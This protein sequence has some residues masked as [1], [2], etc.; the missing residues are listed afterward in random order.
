MDMHQIPRF[1]SAIL[2]LV[3]ATA[4]SVRSTVSPVTGTPVTSTSTAATT[5]TPPI[6]LE[7][8]RLGSAEAQCATLKVHENRVTRSGRVIELRVALIKAQSES[9]APDPIFYLAGGPG[10]AAT[11]DGAR[12]QFPYSLVLPYQSHSLSDH[13]A[14][15]V[16]VVHRGRVYPDG[17]GR[18]VAYR[19]SGGYSANSFHHHLLRDRR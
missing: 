8:C 2:V 11:E 18:R 7:P 4:C 12:K 16:H 1:F 5:I 15:Y 17:F 13:T 10:D 19:L 3:L 9:P 6:R 14:I